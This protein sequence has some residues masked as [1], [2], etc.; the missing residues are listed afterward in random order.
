MQFGIPNT[1]IP[2]VLANSESQSWRHLDPGI[3]VLQKLDQIGVLD[4]TVSQKLF[5]R[6]KSVCHAL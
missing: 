5:M 4:N 2:A 3:S 6:T 1:G